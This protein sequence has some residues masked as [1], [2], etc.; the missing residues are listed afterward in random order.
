MRVLVCGGRD[1]RSRV[2]LHAGLDKLHALNPISEVIEGGAEGADRFANEWA[3][4]HGI[5]STTVPA[6]WK[7]YGKRAGYVRNARM[8]DMRPAMVLAAPGG[9]GTNMMVVIAQQKGIPV[10]MLTYMSLDV[11][12]CDLSALVVG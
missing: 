4:E 1:F 7:T 12:D 5:K 8:A 2:W 3:R 9:K 10:A 6:D 11:T